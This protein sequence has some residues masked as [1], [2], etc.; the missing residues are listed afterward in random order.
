MQHRA[1][2]GGKNCADALEILWSCFDFRRGGGKGGA[3]ELQ[4][5]FEIA[6]GKVATMKYGGK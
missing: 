6:Q 5:I 1:K 4:K 3:K 2:A